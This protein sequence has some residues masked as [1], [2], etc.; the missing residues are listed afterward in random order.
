MPRSPQRAIPTFALYGEPGAPGAEL[1]HIEAI[2]S[3]SAQY[4]WEIEAHVHRGLHQIVWL[5]AGPAEVWLDEQRQRCNGPL[6]IVIPTGAVHAFRFAPQ[7]DGQVLTLSPGLL[8]EGDSPAVGDALRALFSRSQMLRLSAGEEAAQRIEGL[9]HELAA[10]CRAPGPAGTP[11][12]LWLARALVWRLAQISRQQ[13]Q[14]QHD[15]GLAGRAHQPLFTRFVVL[16]EAHFLEHWPL[17]RYAS[18]LGLTAER[19]NRLVRAET[20]RNALAWV[21]ARLAREACRRV[22][23]VAAPIS[24][25]AAELGFDDPAYFCRFFK[26]HTGHSPRAYRLAHATGLAQR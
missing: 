16:V 15:R 5:H 21:H 8:V 9:F 17:S 18:R 4:Q 6:A 22:V 11:V 3:R 10:E 24:S 20:D 26:R 1:L 13:Q 19:L 2:Q 7:S 23:Y 14:Q 25:L 12:P